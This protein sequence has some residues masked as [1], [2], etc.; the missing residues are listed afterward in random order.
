MECLLAILGVIFLLGCTAG[1]Q[2]R[3]NSPVMATEI[4]DFD[5]CVAAGYRVLRSYPPRCVTA[6]GKVFT[7]ESARGEMKE[8]TQG[9]LCVDQCG[10]GVCQQI[11]CMAEGCACPEDPVSCPRDC[12]MKG[13]AGDVW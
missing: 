7:Q 11:V 5:Q 10:N 12:A 4:S 13:G 3:P 6:E 8:N 9:N 1:V 2:P